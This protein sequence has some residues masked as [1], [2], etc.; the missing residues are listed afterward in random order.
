LQRRLGSVLATP[1]MRSK[2]RSWLAASPQD[3]SS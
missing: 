1:V 3:A 2:E